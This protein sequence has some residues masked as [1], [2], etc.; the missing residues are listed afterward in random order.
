[1][2]KLRETEILLERD[3][4]KQSLTEKLFSQNSKIENNT[5]N[6]IDGATALKLD[7]KF[8]INNLEEQS[9]INNIETSIAEPDSE[10]DNA[11]EKAGTES[12]IPTGVSI[13]SASYMESN[14]TNIS[15]NALT[16][17]LI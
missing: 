5:F 6:S 9:I 12:N 1:M 17:C 16:N 3:H 13:E 2:Q 14:N 15:T 10:N 7:E 4:L 8:E 11:L